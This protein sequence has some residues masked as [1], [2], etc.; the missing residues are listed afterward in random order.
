MRERIYSPLEKPWL[1]QLAQKIL[2]PGARTR[3]IRE[4]GENLQGLPAHSNLLDIGCGPESWLFEVGLRPVGLDLSERYIAEWTRRGDRG[5]VGSADALPFDTASFDGVW[6]IGLLHHLPHATV[7]KTMEECVRVCQHRDGYLVIMDS[8]WPQAAWKRPLAWLIRRLDRGEFI[9][10]EAQLRGLLHP[11]YKWSVR[12]ITYS[13]TGLE[14][15]VC[16]CRFEQ[17]TGEA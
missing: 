14:M 5:V 16:V 8:V 11:D 13:L 3:L 12:R 15:L 4:L 2:A 7:K 10:T 6:S 17:T 1:Y 9:R